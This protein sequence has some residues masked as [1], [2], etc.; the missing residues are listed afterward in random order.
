MSPTGSSPPPLSLDRV[1]GQHTSLLS[2]TLYSR[3]HVTY[4]MTWPIGTYNTC[5]VIAM[6][7]EVVKGGVS[8]EGKQEEVTGRTPAGSLAPSRG[9]SPLLTCP[10]L[11]VPHS[12]HVPHSGSKHMTPI[13]GHT[14]QINPTPLS[15]TNPR[16]HTHRDIP[17]NHICICSRA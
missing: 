1:R 7:T 8:M 17:D 16:G 5:T 2:Q 15:A 11:S 10:I 6:E 12:H 3:G 9:V 13:G 4:H 14:H